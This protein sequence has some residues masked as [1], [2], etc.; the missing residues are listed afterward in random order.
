[1]KHSL[2]RFEE[3]A[4]VIETPLAP[5]PERTHLLKT[6]STTPQPLRRTPERVLPEATWPERSVP[7]RQ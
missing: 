7:I 1:M 6:L 3:A 5:L 4:P 2:K